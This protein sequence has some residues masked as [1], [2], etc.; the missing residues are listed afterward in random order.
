[1]PLKLLK[2]QLYMYLA[3]TTNLC[4][5]SGHLYTTKELDMLLALT[6]DAAVAT[7]ISPRYHLKINKF[8]RERER[9]KS[10]R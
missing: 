2:K 4:P 1:M 7:L 5:R 9:E 8:I 10:C 6:T 3:V